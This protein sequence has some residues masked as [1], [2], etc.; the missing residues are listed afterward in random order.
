MKEYIAKRR[1]ILS[2]FFPFTVPPAGVVFYLMMDPTYI[3]TSYTHTHTLLRSNTLSL[4]YLRF[5]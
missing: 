5:R 2:S 3:H 1:G 4:F